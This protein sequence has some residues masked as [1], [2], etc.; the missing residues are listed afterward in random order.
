MNIYI[1]QFIEVKMLI[2]FLTKKIIK[3][4]KFFSK[5]KKII[6]PVHPRVKINLKIKIIMLKM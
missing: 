2:Y 3:L 6:I 4:I 5:I 1:V